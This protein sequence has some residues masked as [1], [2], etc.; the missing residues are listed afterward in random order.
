[1]YCYISIFGLYLKIIKIIYFIDF[2][3]SIFFSFRKNQNQNL[4]LLDLS[5][6]TNQFKKKISYQKV[7]NQKFFY[8]LQNLFI[9]LLI[10]LA[11]QMPSHLLI[12]TLMLMNHLIYFLLL[13][14]HQKN[15]TKRRKHPS[16]LQI[17]PKKLKLHLIYPSRF[18]IY[19]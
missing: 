13:Q 19:L 8:L 18:Q 6:L 7:S 3:L 16:R 1:M 4:Q 2:S 9:L 10:L 5:N 12:Y 11:I 17:Y 14:N 15:Q